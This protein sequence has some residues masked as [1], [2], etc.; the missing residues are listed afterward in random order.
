M[1]ALVQIKHRVAFEPIIDGARQFMGQA[2][3]RCALARLVGQAGQLLRPWRLM[4]EEQHGCFGKG[5][6]AGRGAAFLARGAIAFARGFSGPLAQA[7]VGDDIRP[8]GEA[9]HLMPCIE[10]HS[11]QAFPHPRERPQAVE[12]VSV[13]VLGGW[14]ESPLE[15]GE[16][17]VVRGA[18]HQVPIVPREMTSAPWSWAI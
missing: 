5:P 4:P 16:E 17:R 14:H 2:G 8:A 1:H 3:Q 15:V 10:P 6:P 11:S 7:A 13:V 18:E 9:V 12:G